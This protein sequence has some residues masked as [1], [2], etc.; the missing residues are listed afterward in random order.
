MKGRTTILRFPLA[1]IAWWTVPGRSGL[2]VTGLVSRVL[3]LAVPVLFGELV[4]RLGAGTAPAEVCLLACSVLAVDLASTLASW[5][6]E[7]LANN[8]FC[9]QEV[10]LKSLV[11]SHIEALPTLER[12]ASSEGVWLQKLSR[13][14]TVV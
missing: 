6:N 2:L 13:D 12:E 14:V 8:A 4:S 5:A 10:R 11:W 3:L 7:R 9:A 1:R